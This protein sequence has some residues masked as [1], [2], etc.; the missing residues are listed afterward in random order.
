MKKILFLLL[1]TLVISCSSNVTKTLDDTIGIYRGM[2]LDSAKYFEFM[3]GK[4]VYDVE[5]DEKIYEVVVSDII[6]NFE[7][8]EE[9]RY[10]PFSQRSVTHTELIY[11]YSPY[12]FIFEN[13][14]LV[15]CG[16]A[17]EFKRQSDI[18]Y[19][20]IIEETLKLIKK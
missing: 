7:S 13:H 17:Y 14:L 11:T 3:V 18:R 5:V 1:S 6:S 12:Y 2:P 4:T 9:R 15:Y 10:S 16:Y 20:K 19:S 8:N